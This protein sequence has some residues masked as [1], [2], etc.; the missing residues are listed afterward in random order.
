MY[1]YL[2]NGED[3]TFEIKQ[4][5]SLF[6]KLINK[7]N[8]W[9]LCNNCGDVLNFLQIKLQKNFQYQQLL[10]TV[11]YVKIIKS[12]SFNKDTKPDISISL[13]RFSEKFQPQP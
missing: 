2:V 12:K 6:T 9:T 13:W 8:K 11:Q 4:N 10:T 3:G 7:N 5:G 1:L